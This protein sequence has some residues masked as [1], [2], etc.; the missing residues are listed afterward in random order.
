MALLKTIIDF[1]IVGITLIVLS[2][3]GMGIF[4]LS[5]LGLNK[6]MAWVIYKI[7]Q[8]WSWLLIACTGCKLTVQGR[9]HIP[10]KGGLCFVSNHGSIFDILIIVALVGRPVG[11]IAKKELALIPFL[12]LWIFLLGGLFVDR[13]NIRKA[14]GT[15]QKGVKRIQAGGS[16]VIFPEGTRSHGQGLLP[17]RAG[18]LKLAT[19]AKAPIVPIVIQGSYEIFEKT[20]RVRAVPVRA[21]FLPPIDTASLSAEERR[22]HLSNQVYM[23]IAQ[24]LQVEPAS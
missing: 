24:A 17:F 4:L 16:M 11:F 6:S 19:Q 3:L 10:A 7:A 18:A 2:P 22:Q 15:M 5:R 20:L 9:E 12:N 8:V 23:Q 13:K 14:L 21:T 1:T